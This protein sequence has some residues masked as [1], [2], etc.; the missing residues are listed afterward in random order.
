MELAGLAEG[1]A[2]GA[3]LVAKGADVLAVGEMGLDV[4][5]VGVVGPGATQPVSTS[6]PATTAAGSLTPPTLLGLGAAR[7]SW[8]DL[9]C[10]LSLP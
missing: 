2:P 5:V 9:Q 4:A 6:S 10:L 1:L 3:E 7:V 8:V